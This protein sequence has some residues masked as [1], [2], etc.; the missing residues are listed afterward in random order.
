[1]RLKTLN[2]FAWLEFASFHST[3]FVAAYILLIHLLHIFVHELKMQEKNILLQLLYNINRIEISA[4]LVLLINHVL[5]K[6]CWFMFF[7]VISCGGMIV[8]H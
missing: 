4:Q 2:V 3:F 8:Q 1:M 6:E 5:K 7:K